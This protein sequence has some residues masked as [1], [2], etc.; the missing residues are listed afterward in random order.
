V[1]VGAVRRRDLGDAAVGIRLKL[2]HE[3]LEH[4]FVWRG[5]TR[6][7]GLEAAGR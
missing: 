3:L 2:H 7:R 6:E 5:A 1:T 4:A